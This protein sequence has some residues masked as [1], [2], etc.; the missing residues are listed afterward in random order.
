M[1]KLEQLLQ[2]IRDDAQVRRFQELEQVID[3]NES[4]QTKYKILLDAQKDMVQAEVKKL[5]RYESSKNRYESLRDE[6]LDHPLMGEYLDLLEAINND[7]SLIRT[8]IEEEIN[9]DLD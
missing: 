6:L 2:L 3:Q 5:P 8:I 1:D 7:L 9:R 4:L